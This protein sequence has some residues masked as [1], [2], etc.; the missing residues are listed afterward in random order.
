MATLNEIVYNIKNLAYGGNSPKEVNISTEQ[1]KHWVHYHRAKLIADNIDKGILSNHVIW[2]ELK[3][4]VHNYNNAAVRMLDLLWD[5]YWNDISLGI[6]TVDFLAIQNSLSGSTPYDKDFIQSLPVDQ[7]GDFNGYWIPGPNTMSG[8]DMH[9][10]LM[11]KEN[12][13]QYGLTTPSSQLRGDF[14]NIGSSEFIIPEILMLKNHGSIKDVS[15]RRMV[16]AKDV[17]GEGEMEYKQ[18]HQGGPQHDFIHLPMKTIDEASYSDFNRFS[19]S[20]KPHAVL[21]RTNRTQRASL[22]T[23]NT[24]VGYSLVESYRQLYEQADIHAGTLILGLEGLQISPNYFLDDTTSTEKIRWAYDGYLR[25]IFSNPT[26]IV[27]TRKYDHFI[28]SGGAFSTSTMNIIDEVTQG[29]YK[30]RDFVGWDDDKSPYPIPAE[31][32]KDLIDRVI[33]S[34]VSISTKVMA[35][36]VRDNVDTTKVMQYGSKVQG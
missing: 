7:N 18:D 11:G 21:K 19:S 8:K 4:D 3:L 13:N 9:D 23:T 33:A 1:I 34:E 12:R 26:E 16:H 31:Y 32:I 2:Q 22:D 10:G 35:D 27:S 15:L 5:I 14:R 25:A 6:P 36:E 17:Q 30:A 28:G 24:P 29:E 20:N